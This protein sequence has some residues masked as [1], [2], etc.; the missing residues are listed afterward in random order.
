MINEPGIFGLR[1]LHLAI[2]WS[3]GI[4]TLLNH[5]AEVNVYDDQNFRPVDHAIWRACLI[6]VTLLEETNFPTFGLQKALRTRKQAGITGILDYLI[7][8]EVIRRRK[9]RAL[10]IN[11][12]PQ[13]RTL[14]FLGKD[15]LLD[16]YASDAVSALRHHNV[17]IPASLS[18]EESSRTVYHLDSLRRDVA[19]SFWKAG[20]R[21]ISELDCLGNTPLMKLRVSHRE[22]DYLELIDWFEEKGMK[23][24]ETV[25]HIHSR[26]FSGSDHHSALCPC[27]TS[28]HTVLHLIANRVHSG[29]GLWP[30][31]S[32]RSL[33]VFQGILMNEKQDA[34]KCACSLAGCRGTNIFLKA[35][36]RNTRG[37]TVFPPSK[38]VEKWPSKFLLFCLIGTIIS[39]EIII[40]VIR[41]LTFDTLGLTHTCC[42]P[43]DGDP[44]DLIPFEDGDEIQEIHDEEQEDLRLL[45]IL[46]LEFD[47]YRRKSNCSVRDFFLTYWRFRMIEVLSE[48]KPFN[49]DEF[50]EIGV[51][52]HASQRERWTFV[53]MLDKVVNELTDNLIDDK[54]QKSL[55]NR[56]SKTY[57]QLEKA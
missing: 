13:S 6:S 53:H 1:P 16:A 43:K 8:V 23:I 35:W 34:C 41:F 19:E 47:E 3:S 50:R 4:I 14:R 44:K 5:G 10:V 45:E 52:L 33:S 56:W 36:S 40:D 11:H 24:D 55:I 57:R 39:E 32:N 22:N 46:L 29:I 27:L 51:T 37:F 21:D 9:L 2:G 38:I 25:Q 30:F 31:W 15:R 49:Q 12:L 48:E 20:F 17:S 7:N 18:F 54:L 28:G 42:R 26:A